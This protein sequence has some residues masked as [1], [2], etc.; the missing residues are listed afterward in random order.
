MSHC[1]QFKAMT[2][3]ATEFLAQRRLSKAYDLL[4]E[5]EAVAYNGGMYSEAAECRKAIGAIRKGVIPT[6]LRGC[7]EGDGQ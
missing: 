1:E 4:H 3:R 7:G 6:W 2:K 5:A